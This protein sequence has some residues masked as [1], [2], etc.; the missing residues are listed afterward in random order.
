MGLLHSINQVPYMSIAKSVSKW[1]LLFCLLAGVSF[2]NAQ[3]LDSLLTVLEE[4]E[5]DSLEASV[6]Y[7]IGLSHSDIDSGVYFF[8]QALPIE[9]KLRNNLNIGKI[10]SAIGLKKFR[11]NDLD[12]AVFYWDQSTISFANSYDSNEESIVDDLMSNAHYNIGLGHYYSNNLSNSIVAIRASL[13]IRL[14]YDESEPIISCYNIL[15]IIHLAQEEYDEAETYLDSGLDMAI[16][17]NDTSSAIRMYT[18]LASVYL[19][20]DRFVK[21]LDYTQK[22]YHLRG[23][24]AN[25]EN[26]DIKMNIGSIYRSMGKLDTA[27]I[28][29][30]E[31]V[32]IFSGS[33][34]LRNRIMSLNM[35]ADLYVSTEE[36]KELL[37][38]SKECM[39]LYEDYDDL[40]EQEVTAY[41]LSVAY[42]NLG[43]ENLAHE[44]FK[45]HTALKDSLFTQEKSKEIDRLEAK[46]Q[47][48]KN[49]N[50]IA[51]LTEENLLKEI[52]IAEDKK[53]KLVFLIFIGF[54]I[55]FTVI[56]LLIYKRKQDRKRHVLALKKMEIEQRMI[57]SQMN[58]H[59]IF[60]ALNS[61]Q[62]YI[63][64]NS[65]YE[66][67]VFL[68][69]FSM[70]IRN[71]LENSM[72]EFIDL[73][74]EIETLT[75]YLELE[76]IRFNDKFEYTIE[77]KLPDPSIQ[78]PPMLVQPFVENALVHGI[79]GKASNGQ[80]SICFS[81][82]ENE[83][84][85]CEIVDNGVGRDPTNSRNNHQSLSTSLTS[86]RIQFFNK[87][88][89]GNYDINIIDL[90][91]ADGT[92][93]GTKVE[94][95]IPS[96]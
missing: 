64:T 50:E 92:A 13:K 85:L 62:S 36:W 17:D 93:A 28:I 32:E 67:E 42:E 94:L 45:L 71:I 23:G 84:T 75:L 82:A 81:E 18:N 72:N 5:D 58:P 86:D 96:N 38:V 24:M 15:G 21:A 30:R 44:N 26:A 25:E 53:A 31:G 10:N 2:S 46:Y 51:S 54:F 11:Q 43:N 70:L 95:L 56:F 49:E 55:L 60:N 48:E 39:L 91:N 57:R 77:V 6:L 74:D 78:I 7:T 20:K 37:E 22:A 19:R 4:V 87:E 65:T 34:D 88:Q 69:K 63:S 9:E 33:D 61:I 52:Q 47:F 40:R 29:L 79:K 73:D 8:K 89:R 68:S 27:R 90:K 3:N 59:F 16:E 66:A 14:K 80:I 35:L 41:N 12:S 83:T 76:K 1:I